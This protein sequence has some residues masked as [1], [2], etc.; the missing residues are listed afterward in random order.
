MQGLAVF[1]GAVFLVIFL[2]FVRI[3]F[4]ACLWY[5]FDDSLAD[6]SGASWVGNVP[7][8]V[9]LLVALFLSVIGTT[10]NSQTNSK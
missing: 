9:S 3:I 6:I 1:T 10:A 5:T 7:L 4:I 2:V 8:S